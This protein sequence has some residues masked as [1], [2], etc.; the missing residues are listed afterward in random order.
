MKK[1]ITV[2]RKHRGTGRKGR[3]SKKMN[4][5]R[6]GGERGGRGCVKG[7]MN[8]TRAKEKPYIEGSEK[9]ESERNY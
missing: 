2:N 6:R 3:E 4:G 9:D 1:Q 5:G 8:R 7:W